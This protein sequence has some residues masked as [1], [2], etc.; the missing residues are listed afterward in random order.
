MTKVQTK[1]SL[2]R[3]LTEKDLESIQHMHSVIGFLAV[4]VAPK[5]DEL[6]VEYDYS[7][8]TPDEVRGSLDN[9]GIPVS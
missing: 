1:F 6:W 9:N 8:L 4:R 7:R 5:G 3:A 2:S